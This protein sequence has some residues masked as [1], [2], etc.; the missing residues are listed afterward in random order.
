[1]AAHSYSACPPAFSDGLTGG[2]GSRKRDLRRA[3]SALLRQTH[4]WCRCSAIPERYRP[5]TPHPSPLARIPPPLCPRNHHRRRR[6]VKSDACVRE[7]GG[8][9]G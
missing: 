8:V 4:G 1:M 9:R 7:E 3:A 6:R 5:P 2:V